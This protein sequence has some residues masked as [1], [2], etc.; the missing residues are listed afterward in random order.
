MKGTFSSLLQL[1]ID[2]LFRFKIK[3]NRTQR[4]QNKV[5]M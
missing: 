1:N 5:T 3:L 4:K 2:N